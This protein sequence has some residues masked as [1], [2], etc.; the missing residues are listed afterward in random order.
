MS[1][2][3]DFWGE[4]PAGAVPAARKAPGRHISATGAP[5]AATSAPTSGP[6]GAAQGAEESPQL[7]LLSAFW[8]EEEPSA[9]G[10]A[11]S[12]EREQALVDTFFAESLD[13][14][15]A[16]RA[17]EESKSRRVNVG[18]DVRDAT[19]LEELYE[20][21]RRAGLKNVSRARIL[22]VAL[23]HFHTCWLTRGD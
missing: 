8:G 3:D 16:R 1:V 17:A 4:P 5:S 22:R 11:E 15:T 19:L 10:R 13:N 6:Q 23:R 21:S 7:D 20:Q 12:E 18:L 2:D 9:G 14:T